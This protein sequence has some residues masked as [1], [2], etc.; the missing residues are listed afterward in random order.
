MTAWRLRAGLAACA[1]LVLSLLPAHGAMAAPAGFD[2]AGVR[3]QLCAE[4]WDTEAVFGNDVY[5]GHD[6]PSTL[7][8]SNTPGSGNRNQYLLQLPKDPPIQPNQ[9][10]TGGT[11]N[12]QLHPAFFFGMAMCDTQSAPEFTDQCTPDSDANIFDDADPASP[13]YIGRH[14]GAA[15]MEMQFYPPGWAQWPA[16]NSCDT[17]QWCAALNIDSLST[18][19]NNGVQNNAD[20]LRKVG[21][22][23][24]NFAFITKNGA[25]HAPAG[26]LSATLATF[27]PDP[28]ADLFM[29]SGDLVLVD[30]LDTAAGFQVVLHDLTAG[31]VGSMTASVANGFQQVNFQPTASTCTAAPY[32]FHPMYSTSSEH[33]RVPWAAHSYNVDFSDETG[34]FQY[35]NSVDTGTGRCLVAGGHDAGSPPDADDVGCFAASQLPAGS[36]QVSGCL[37]TDFDFDGVPY[38]NNWPGTL[39]NPGQDRKFHAQPIRFT[40]PVTNGFTQFDRVAF[41]ADLPRIELQ[42]ANPCNRTT[43]ANC[44]NPPPGADFYPFFT[45]HESAGGLAC[46]WQEGGAHIPGTA[47]TFGGSSTTEYGPL[48]TLT[49]PGAGFQPIHRINNFRQVLP[50]NPCRSGNFMDRESD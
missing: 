3:S 48:L 50:N 35:C 46:N 29:R 40:S 20:C 42:V 24:V 13:H 16:G 18:D 5:V 7:F 25:A 1:G 15:F 14:P 33:T 10:G 34:H 39:A 27:T 36:V 17:R 38:F 43:G 8:Y 11:F 21:Q 30:L 4:V 37:G 41:E 6:E 47:N 9:A 2:C 23:P 32:A 12:F 45:T 49:Y 19:Q 31:R 28:A 26:P 22:E 44:V